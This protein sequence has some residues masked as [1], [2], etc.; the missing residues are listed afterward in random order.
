MVFKILTNN[1]FMKH[2]KNEVRISG[3]HYEKSN[4]LYL[5]K[6]TP[7]YLCNNQGKV[8]PIDY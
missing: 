3:K 7:I 8:H 4:S 2:V 6:C 1:V 5:R